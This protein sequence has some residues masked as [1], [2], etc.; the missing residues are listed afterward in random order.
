MFGWAGRP[1]FRAV[2]GIQYNTIL[3]GN[4]TS[5]IAAPSPPPPPPPPGFESP[6]C[7]P[8]AGS[9]EAATINM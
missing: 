9:G 2:V 1:S 4:P 8:V 5:F 3:Y 6:A 7:L